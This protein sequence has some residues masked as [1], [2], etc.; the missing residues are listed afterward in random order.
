M[1]FYNEE[2]RGPGKQTGAMAVQSLGGHG[3]TT[4]KV[5]NED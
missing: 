5:E 2:G 1:R 4:K 3:I